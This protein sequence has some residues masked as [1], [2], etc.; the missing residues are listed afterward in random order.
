MGSVNFI[1]EERPLKIYFIPYLASGHLI[2]Q[3]DIARLFASRGHHV[4]VLTTPS[5]AQL[6]LKSNPYRHHNY[7]V[8]TF[9]FPSDQVGLPA[10]IEN[11]AGITTVDDSYKLYYGT[12]LLQ[13]PLTN[14]IEQDPPDCIVGDF[15]YPWLHD[16]AIKLRI[17]RFAFN[18]FSLFTICAMESLRLH[19]MQPTG[20]Y[21][22]PDLPHKI[23]M[24]AVP[25]KFPK[26]FL[27]VLLET[28]AKSDGLLVNNFLELDGEEYVQYYKKITGHKAWHLGPAC[29]VRRT[30]E[31]KAE[32]GPEKSV[33]NVEDCLSW[34]D[35]RGANSVVYVSFGTV[36]HF[37]DNQLY[38]IACGVEASGCEFIWVV[39]EKKG[40]ESESEEE[41]EKWLPKGFEERN[42]KK[43]IIIRGWAPQVLILGHSAVGAMLTHCGWNSTSEAVSAGV[44]MITWPLHSDQFYNEKLISEVRGIGVEIGVDEWGVYCY[45]QKEKVVGRVEIEKGVRRL[46]DGG[47][48]AEQI[49]RRVQEFK[50]KA[51]EAVQEGGSSYNNL[52]SLIHEIKRL[53]DSKLH[54]F[55]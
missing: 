25:P 16:L 1:N 53:R 49:R 44:P 37:P 2:P 12:M 11:L 42:K 10:G 19:R 30:S 41:K 43:G 4:T 27:E 21:L 51:R 55:E 45:G 40:K 28:E 52:T 54:E 48:E 23:T 8:Q 15:L 50:K 14:F 32:R 7:R 3:S 38:E 34:L 20:P 35:S 46:M 13:E 17:P 22:I 47:D 6:F 39:P 9:Q 31:E 33:L 26:D 5:N 36:C 24:N 29:L 18:G